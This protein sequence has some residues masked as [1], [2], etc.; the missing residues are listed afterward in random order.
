MGAGPADVVLVLKGGVPMYGDAPVMEALGAG[1]GQCELMSDC[2]SG[3]R[4]C[5]TRDGTGSG[6]T[7]ASLTATFTNYPLFDCSGAPVD[8]PTCVPFRDEGDGIAYAGVPSGGDL[9]GDGVADSA[10]NCPTVFNPPRP[11]DGFVQGDE[12]ADGIG[13]ACDRC[14]IYTGETVCVPFFTT[15]FETGDT[16]DWSATSS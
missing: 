14:P 11:V 3:K 9:D 8:E 13:D 6:L 12:D 7:L 4:V 5:V 10:D 15:D 1:D 2:L 16:T